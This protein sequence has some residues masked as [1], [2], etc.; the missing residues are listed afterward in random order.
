M[1]YGVGY[2]FKIHVECADEGAKSSLLERHLGHV[3]EE[4]VK[5]EACDEFMQ[6][7]TIG[8]DVLKGLVE[9]DLEI[10]AKSPALAIDQALT[11]IRTAVHA[12]GGYTGSWDADLGD[13]AGDVEYGLVD[14]EAEPIPC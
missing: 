10:K 13:R 7:P 5:L 3:M 9:V 4:L 1:W 2:R 14:V 6:D 8:G 12:A 11:S